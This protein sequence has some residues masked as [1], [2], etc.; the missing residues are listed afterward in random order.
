MSQTIE[1]VQ[2]VLDSYA[3]N[4][5]DERTGLV[6]K[7][8]ETT[9]DKDSWNDN[10]EG[11]LVEEWTN[12]V[13][14]IDEL[15]KRNAVSAS[16][17]VEEAAKVKPKNDFE[18]ESA[19]RAAT[20][21]KYI[22]EGPDS[23]ELDQEKMLGLDK[24]GS[25]N[26]DFDFSTNEMIANPTT[27]PSG[28]TPLTTDPNV[29]FDL[30]Q[31]GGMIRAAYTFNSQKGEARNIPQLN[32]AGVASQK[33]EYLDE[34]NAAPISVNTGSVQDIPDFED[35]EYPKIPT[36]HSK[37]IRMTN[38]FDEDNEI[39]TPRLLMQECYRRVGR[40]VNEELTYGSMS[41]KV[42]GIV[43]NTAKGVDVTSATLTGAAGF[44]SLVDLKGS[45]DDA[46]IRGELFEGGRTMEGGYRGYMFSQ[47][48]K[49]MLRKLKDSDG[50]PYFSPHPDGLIYGW[51]GMIDGDPVIINNDM[52]G[53][54]NT[55]WVTGDIPILYGNF[56]YYGIRR[57]VRVR[58]N[59][60]EDSNFASSNSV[61]FQLIIRMDGRPRGALD[62]S[63][64]MV[65]VK[66]MLTTF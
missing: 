17:V 8:T 9:N 1:E 44:D 4:L 5:N 10:V 35:V 18:D 65:A 45:I 34:N 53:G 11:R 49:T 56:G 61:G 36:F 24:G 46:Y 30:R 12:R 48:T 7:I 59:R 2:G 26:F 55:A 42:V 13:E 41:G 15:I 63:N 21:E 28:V 38:E 57:F 50:R 43:P 62:S 51:A 32:T 66:H 25:A 58:F 64:N 47:H 29:I 27:S 19:Y 14:E 20:M 16:R 31:Q 33:G 60:Y 54:V 6:D 22:A 52:A 40:I 37:I 3:K 23:L 39:N